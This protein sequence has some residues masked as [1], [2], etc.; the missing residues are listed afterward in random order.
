MSVNPTLMKPATVNHAGKPVPK[1]RAGYYVIDEHR[2]YPS[3][4][5]ILQVIA[6]P[7]LIHWSA[8]VTAEAL[9]EDPSLDLD[10]AIAV[11]KMKKEKAGD[12]G[13]TVHSWA[14]AYKQ[15]AKLTPETL[16]E[17]LQGYGRAMFA[18]IEAER[19][20]ILHNELEVYSD[21]HRIAGKTD[22]VVMVRGKCAVVDLK[23]SKGI[24]PEYGLQ[25]S[26]YKTCLNEMRAL[27]LAGVIPE[28]EDTYV[29]HIKADGNYEFRRMDEPFDAFLAAKRLWEW[30]QKK[31]G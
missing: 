10:Q 13:S 19:P 3:I 26:A 1:R 22:M 9:M 6:K 14:E 23:T 27:A 7:A 16:P 30:Q 28:V 31:E 2:V 11:G 21:L 24:Y 5:T 15:G 8:K 17:H 29:L 4:T 12:A 20:K 18:W 25:I